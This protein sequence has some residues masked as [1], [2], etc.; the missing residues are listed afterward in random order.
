VIVKPMRGVNVAVTLFAAFIVNTQLLAVP[1]QSPPHP[2]KVLV[3]D[4]KM[5][6]LVDGIAV[7]VT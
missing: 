7:S 5:L 6:L 1:V 4:G 3:V 2:L